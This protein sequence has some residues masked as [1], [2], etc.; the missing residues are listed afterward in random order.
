MRMIA[1]VALLAA[2]LLLVSVPWNCC[3]AAPASLPDAEGSASG[4]ETQGAATTAVLQFYAALSGA[5]DADTATLLLRITAPDWVS[6]G[7]NDGCRARDDVISAIIARRKAVPDLKWTVR[8][9]LVTGNRIV[10]R[11]QA[12]GTPTGNFM[13][14]PYSGKSFDIMSIDMHT[15]QDGKIIRSYHVE[16]WIGAVRQLSAE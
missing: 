3:S 7:A 1:P 8:D 13:S 16:D 12:T 6:C 4:S 11:G 15:V 9:V 2:P 5:G 14:V 10:V